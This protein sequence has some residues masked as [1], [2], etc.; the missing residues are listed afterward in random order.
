MASIGK[1]TDNQEM[2]KIFLI[3]TVLINCTVSVPAD[4]PSLF[5]GLLNG[6]SKNC[7]TETYSFLTELR[8]IEV[9]IKTFIYI[10]LQPQFKIKYN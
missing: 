4:I 6:L 3:F 5:S 8:E 2:L 10:K 7:L 1:L 9:L